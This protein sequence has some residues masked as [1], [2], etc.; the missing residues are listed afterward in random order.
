MARGVGNLDVLARK[1]ESEISAL[2]GMGPDAVK[3]LKM[4]SK[5]GGLSFAKR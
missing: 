4:A 5:Q 1:T 3:S 2:H